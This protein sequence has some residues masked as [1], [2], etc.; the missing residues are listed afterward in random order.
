MATTSLLDLAVLDRAD[1][2]TG[3]IED[4]TSLAPEF[5]TFGAHRRPGTWYKIVKR[6]TLPTIQFRNSNAG[7]TT[8]KS[9]YKSEIKQMFFM[10]GRLNMDESVWDADTAHLGAL[11]QLEAAGAVRSASILIGQQTWYGTS[12]DSAG[13]TGVRSQLSNTV[14][15]GYHSSA[16]STSAYLVWMDEQHGCR[17]DVG[18]DGQFAIS[19]PLRQQITDP[20]DSTKAYFAYVGNLKAWIGFNVGSNLSCW[21]ITGIA[22]A[23]VANWMTDDKASQLLAKIPVA[24]R[25]NLRWFMNRT[26]ESFLQRSRSTFNVGIFATGGTNN[27]MSVQPANAGGYPAMSPL[28]SSCIGYPITLTDSILDTETNS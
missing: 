22:S 18:M 5:T 11:W 19:A 14:D 13:F 3:L 12:S 16:A 7:V 2:Y 1:E 17:Y 8:S 24:R 15:A 23:A 25:S 4:V 27:P 21:G 10:D 6:T 9:G 20:N 28:P 26:T